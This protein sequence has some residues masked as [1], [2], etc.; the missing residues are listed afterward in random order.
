MTWNVDSVREQFPA[1]RQWIHD[2]PLVYFDN[3]ATTQKPLAV[4]EATDDFYRRY[5]ANVH[6]G[7]HRLGELA[8]AA[9]ESA[10]LTVQRFLNAA[11]KDEIIFTRG[12][13][14]A[15]NLVAHSFGQRFV[16]QGDQIVLTTLEHHSNIV[17]W[18]LLC[19]RTGATLRVVPVND[20]GELLL[21]ELE[22]LLT[23][24]TRLIALTH[25]SNALGTVNPVSKVIQAAHRRGIAVLVD[26]AQAVAH[27][28]VDVQALGCDFYVLSGHK[29]FGPTGIGVLY[30]RGE[31]LAQM[32][33]YHGGGDMIRSVTFEKSTYQDPPARFEAGTPN[34]AGA[35]GLAAAINYLK[36]LDMQAAAQHEQ[37]LLSHLTSVLSSEPRVRLVGTAAQR[38]AVASFVI[39]GV[40]PH[41]IATILDHQ[42]VAIR[43][44]HHCAQPLMRR[45]GVSATARASLAFYNTTGEIDSLADGLRKILEMFS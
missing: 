15:I 16:S 31:L 27:Q 38:V 20:A 23:E 40:H 39:E 2:R 34:I 44:G 36:T 7:A 19:E 12:A 18:Q 28:A 24:R 26:G 8:T 17:P 13:T 33:P 42:G 22:P 11:S 1:L 14:E 37:N 43:A 3:A 4:I 25:V 41:D 29:L 5:N 45:L 6:R 35:I 30:G 32:P 10:R 21:D 9:Y